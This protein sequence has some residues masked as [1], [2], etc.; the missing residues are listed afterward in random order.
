MK[1]VQKSFWTHPP[2][3]LMNLNFVRSYI[4]ETRRGSFGGVIRESLGNILCSYSGAVECIDS[5]GT[6]VYAMV[7]GCCELSRR[8]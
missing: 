2:V 5:V 7:M 4:K 3:G 6:E 8:S 1:P